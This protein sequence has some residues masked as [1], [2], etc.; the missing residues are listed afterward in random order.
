MES[1]VFN[2]ENERLRCRR[3]ISFSILE[4]FVLLSLVA[5]TRLC[6]RLSSW[7]MCFPWQRI[8]HLLHITTMTF[9]NIV[10]TQLVRSI[11]SL[12]GISDHRYANW[13]SWTFHKLFIFKI[14]DSPIVFSILELWQVR[15][16][17]A[18]CTYKLF[19]HQDTSKESP[20]GG[21]FNSLVVGTRC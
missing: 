5:F 6:S 15:I 2:M 19:R 4:I 11:S 8:P 3:F 1:H 18:G 17:P 9:A 21:I 13:Q 12:H 7:M 20:P 10:Q 14:F 16:L